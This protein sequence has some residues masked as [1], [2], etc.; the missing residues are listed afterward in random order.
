MNFEYFYFHKVVVMILAIREFVNKW[1][2]E[3]E[4]SLNLLLG[5]ML[6]I[7]INKGCAYIHVEFYIL[8]FTTENERLIDQQ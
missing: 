1:N 3:D 4:I 5:I 2:R 8:K 7:C 6:I